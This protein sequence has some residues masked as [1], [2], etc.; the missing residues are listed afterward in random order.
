MSR[1]CRLSH[2]HP[3]SP[4]HYWTDKVL[5]SPTTTWTPSQPYQSWWHTI[6]LNWCGQ[7]FNWPNLGSFF[8]WGPR[9]KQLRR[10]VSG[11]LLLGRGF[12]LGRFF[13]GGRSWEQNLWGIQ[14]GVCVLASMLFDGEFTSSK[15]ETIYPKSSTFSFQYEYQLYLYIPVYRSCV[16]RPYKY[17]ALHLGSLQT[18]THPLFRV[19]SCEVRKKAS[20]PMSFVPMGSTRFKVKQKLLRRLADDLCS[21]RKRETMTQQKHP[22]KLTWQPKTDEHLSISSCEMLWVFFYWGGGYK[23]DAKP[24]PQISMLQKV[25]EVD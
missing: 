21:K 5:A 8:S 16:L 9:L 25:H 15:Q 20:R 14:I 13:W 24:W 18:W 17:F 11:R 10:W 12:E 19:W 7:L 2:L 3:K 1:C 6:L 22:G 4:S 23:K